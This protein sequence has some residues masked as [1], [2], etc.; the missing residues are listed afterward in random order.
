MTNVSCRFCE[1]T[2]GK[3]GITNHEKICHSNP[4]REDL[5]KICCS[6]CQKYISNANFTR[7]YEY[8]INLPNRKIVGGKKGPRE[9]YTPWNLGLTKD[10]HAGILSA[11]IKNTGKKRVNPT[12]MTPEIK[13][14]ISDSMKLAHKEQRAWNIGKSRWNNK[15]SYPEK[16]FMNVIQNEFNDKDYTREF[17]FNKYSIDFAWIHLKKAIEID[18]DQHQRFEEYKLRDESKDALLIENGWQVLRL[19][20]KTIFNNTQESIKKMKDFIDS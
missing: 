19:P 4:N 1:K 16:W 10:N 7:H 12:P 11:S 18:G 17:P 5:K 3:R 20:W 8:C 2:F 6:N 15:P 9:N 14:K 13:K